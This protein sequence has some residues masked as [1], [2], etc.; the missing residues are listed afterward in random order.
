MSWSIL[1]SLNNTL[2]DKRNNTLFWC[3]SYEFYFSIKYNFIFLIQTIQPFTFSKDCTIFIFKNT[4]TFCNT[5]YHISFINIIIFISIH[6]ITTYFSIVKSTLKY[7]VRTIFYYNRTCWI[8][9]IIRN[10][11]SSGF[12]VKI[13]Y[14]M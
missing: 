3:G 5:I 4:I 7:Y 11:D 12:A 10:R 1:T 6:T 8:I 13:D 14:T 9:T 2:F